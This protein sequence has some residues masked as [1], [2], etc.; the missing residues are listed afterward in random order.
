V[1]VPA[2]DARYP[3][4]HEVVPGVWVREAVSGSA[5]AGLFR[6]DRPGGSAWVTFGPAI[7]EPAAVIARVLRYESAVVAPVRHVGPPALATEP[8]RWVLVEDAPDGPTL[9][10]LGGR[11]ATPLVGLGRALLALHAAGEVAG[12]LR[13]ELVAYGPGDLPTIAPRCEGFLALGDPGD[14]GV[15]PPFWQR[16]RAPELLDGTRQAT[17]AADVYA[18]AAIA[19][20]RLQGRHPFEAAF[21]MQRIARMLSGQ[22][23]LT[24][25]PSGIGPVLSAALSPA[26]TDRPALEALID[27]L[28]AA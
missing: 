17:P 4:D 23:D 26:A 2:D 14:A 25:V 27:A 18:L 3:L 24:G 11:D 15:A 10:E 13:P 1:I 5:L 12:W 8:A 6:A 7:G 22:A 9:K 16:Y 21:D 28:E 20:E 19:A